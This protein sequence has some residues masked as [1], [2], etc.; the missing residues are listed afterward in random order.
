[1]EVAVA[2]EVLADQLRADDQPSLLD[3]AA[4]GLTREQQPAMPVIAER[5]DKAGD[6]GQQRRSSRS[7]DE[8]LAAWT[9]LLTRGAGR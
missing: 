6:H 1:M 8:F 4:I 5:I 2:R 7:R 3:Q 9:C